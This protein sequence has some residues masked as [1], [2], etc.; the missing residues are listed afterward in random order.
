MRLSHLPY[1]ISL[2][3]EPAEMKGHTLKRNIGSQPGTEFAERGL[4]KKAM[5][6]TVSI[7]AKAKASQD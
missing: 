1:P 5:T 3:S 2:S 7:I 6:R 4:T